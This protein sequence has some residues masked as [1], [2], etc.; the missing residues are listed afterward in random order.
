MSRRLAILLAL[1]AVPILSTAADAED[2]DG[3]PGTQQQRASEQVYDQMRAGENARI[4]EEAALRAGSSDQRTSL[5]KAI[6]RLGP[7]YAQNP[8]D[9]P[10][11]QRDQQKK[12]RMVPGPDGTP[13][14]VED[15]RGAAPMYQG[16]FGSLDA[17]KDPNAPTQLSPLTPEMLRLPNQQ[18]AG[19]QMFETV[20]GNGFFGGVKAPTGPIKIDQS[21]FDLSNP[22]AGPA[23]AKDKLKNKHQYVDGQEHH[24]AEDPHGFF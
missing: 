6:S 14:V 19:S 2:W 5:E 11:I 23:W 12:W 20:G 16:G 7:G 22:N 10:D 17:Q 13:M 15:T 24:G 18:G 3:H 4:S 1:A 8:E 21:E 9:N